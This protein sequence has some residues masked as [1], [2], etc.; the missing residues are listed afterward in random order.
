MKL[1][2]L[3]KRYDPY[4]I[5]PPAKRRLRIFAFDPS[6]EYEL[7]KA[8]ISRITVEVPWMDS[9]DPDSPGGPEPGPIGEY[10]EVIDFDPASGY[11]YEPVNLNDIYITA[12]NGLEPSDGN[13]QFHQQMVYAVSMLTIKNFDL[14]LGRCALWAPRELRYEGKKQFE[15][16]PRLRIYPHAMRETN[17]YYSTQ[18]KA[19]LFGY[20]PATPADPGKHLPGGIVFT[21]LSHDI[22]AHE[23]THALLDG[24]HRRYIESSNPDVLSFHEA[25]ADIV[26]IFQHFTFKDAV[27]HQIAKCRGDLETANLLAELAVEF[28]QA[29]GRSGALRS[30]IGTDPQPLLIEQVYEPHKRGSLLVAAV[31]DA[32][33]LI[34]KSRTADLIR[35]ASEGT[36]ILPEGELHPDL[37]NRLASEATKAAQHVLTMCIRALDYLPPID[38]TFG[39]YLRALITA[40]YDLV[41]DDDLGYRVAFIESFRRRGIYPRNVRSLSLESLL[42][43]N[44]KKYEEG[45]D[46][47]YFAS[48]LN[49][50]L[51]SWSLSSNR[52]KTYDEMIRIHKD[53]HEIFERSREYKQN[54][55]EGLQLIDEDK[56]GI[57]YSGLKFEIHS[58]RPVRRVGPDGQLL[59]DVLIEVTQ[60]LPGFFN[61]GL[62][63]I[64][65]LVSETPI[66]ELTPDFWFRGGCT[67]LLDSET[68]EIRY[69][70]YK[71]ITSENRYKRQSNYISGKQ[72]DPSFRE[73]FF[74]SDRF[75]SESEI[76]AFLHKSADEEEII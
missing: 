27:R 55:L 50:A 6:L 23:T 33:L 8:L 19:L 53:V 62:R 29:T 31:F 24:L 61:K 5:E 75:D 7:S 52:E 20:F 25:F 65:K 51:L 43:K 64:W 13:P 21:C 42:W 68:G 30:A 59:T 73:T 26:A 12:N 16:V 22:I 10:V 17:A 58:I 41:P 38:I 67:I 15:Y 56:D 32:F 9:P 40:D 44:P 69:C 18:K 49:K 34:Y 74:G 71:D 60:K 36:G 28:G 72:I 63:D 11:C 35:I 39:E 14:A 45:D 70:I 4:A 54:V 48:D 37:V 3:V 47:I 46:R 76:F 57:F 66:D 1:K 2:S